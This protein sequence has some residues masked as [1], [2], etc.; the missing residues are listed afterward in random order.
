M[1]YAC[2]MKYQILH[3]KLLLRNLWV[4]LWGLFDFEKEEQKNEK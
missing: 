4:V 3:N 2:G 1:W